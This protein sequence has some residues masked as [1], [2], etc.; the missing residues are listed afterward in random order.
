M[1]DS[2]LILSSATCSSELTQ[3][4]QTPSL[5]GFL[6]RTWARARIFETALHETRG[7]GITHLEALALLRQV[8]PGMNPD[9]AFLALLWNV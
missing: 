5:Y 4:S 3:P 6:R 9:A 1:P 2:V 7:D 8:L